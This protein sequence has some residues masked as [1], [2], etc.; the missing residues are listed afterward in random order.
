MKMQS[1]N[2]RKLLAFSLFPFT[3]S[4]G[5]GGAHAQA[6]PAKP[7]RFVIPFP[8]GGSTDLL[9]RIIGQQWAESMGQQVIIDNRGG[10][11]G[12]I[13]VENAARSAPDGYTLVLGHIGT[14]GLNPSLYA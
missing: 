1:K 7:I 3:F 5:I 2:I 14:F 10:A 11:G 12:I 8:P 6:Y 4:L 13:G 9:G